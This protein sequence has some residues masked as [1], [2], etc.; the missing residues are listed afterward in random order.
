MIDF[1]FSTYY[2]EP[3]AEGQQLE[4]GHDKNMNCVPTSMSLAVAAYGKYPEI[5]PQ[6]ITDTEYG[7]NYQGGE[8]FESSI[9]YIH[10]YIDAHLPITVVS[11]DVVAMI[12]DAGAHRFPTIFLG[13]CLGDGTYTTK[14]TGW[15]HASI[16]MRRSNGV[17]TVLNSE[18]LTPSDYTDDELRQIYG[19][20]LCTFE[21]PL[22]QPPAVATEDDMVRSFPLPQPNQWGAPANVEIQE[23][24]NVR[25]MVWDHNN[26]KWGVAID[27]GG[28]LKDITNA[29]EDVKDVLIRGANDASERYSFNS[30]HPDGE[31]WTL[32][33]KP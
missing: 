20:C 22:P 21:Q 26:S 12:E 7:V 9:N 24:G 3:P 23:G 2:P 16:I 4:A 5:E 31:K 11:G 33:Y 6:A 25:V 30:G 15:E 19:G 32:E 17:T 1:D 29:A 14:M 18:W 13:H 10:R 8:S 27:T 28:Q